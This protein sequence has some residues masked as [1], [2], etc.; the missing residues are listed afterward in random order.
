MFAGGQS[1]K[2]EVTDSEIGGLSRF[3]LE[4][5]K[6]IGECFNDAGLLSSEAL[7]GLRYRLAVDANL[8]NGD[9]CRFPN[10]QCLNLDC[11]ECPREASPPLWPAAWKERSSHESVT[12][13]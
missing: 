2:P 12:Q 6:L 5:Y 4:L 3:E 1:K 7:L 13:E 9:L 10:C 11:S 8:L